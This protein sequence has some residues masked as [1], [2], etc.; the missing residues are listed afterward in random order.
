MIVGSKRI[1][2]FQ[3]SR[4]S[5][6]VKANDLVEARY[7]L[8]S[9]EQKLVIAMVSCIEPEDDDFKTYK[10]RI[11]ELGEFMGIKH[12][13]IYKEIYDIAN[14]LRKKDINIY[15]QESHSFINL[16]WLSSSKYFIG[17]GIVELRFDP[18]LKPYLLN[19]KKKFVKYKPEVIKQINSGYSIRIYELLKQYEKI[20]KRIFDI[21]ELR[22]ILGIS[23]SEYKRYFDFKKRVLDPAKQDLN[24]YADIEINFTEIR[25][26]KKVNYIEFHIISN[27]N[28]K[29]GIKDIEA[30]QVISIRDVKQ[31]TLVHIELQSIHNKLVNYLLLSQAQAKEVIGKFSKEYLLDQI[32]NIGRDFANKDIKK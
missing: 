28:D 19:L 32:S 31:V 9:N 25:N 15:D 14:R 13:E 16:G 30:K 24:N 4:K 6:V 20:G 1:S 26:G 7:R 12:R 23:Q 10:F 22:A 21:D 8:T 3:K 5:L 2:L 27:I 17:E 29:D 11:V 18:N